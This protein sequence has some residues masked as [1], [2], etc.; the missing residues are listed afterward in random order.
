MDAGRAA[1]EPS[2]V[3]LIAPCFCFMGASSAPRSLLDRQPARHQARAWD[4]TLGV[5]VRQMGDPR[6]RRLIHP[7]KSREHE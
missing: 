6:K 1:R 3:R 5:P 7:S 4:V 2:T